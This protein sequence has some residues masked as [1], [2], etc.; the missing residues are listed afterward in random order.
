MTCEC[1][2]I[3]PDVSGHA[4]YAFHDAPCEHASC[5]NC[6][7]SGVYPDVLDGLPDSWEPEVRGWL[8]H[9]L[10][11]AEA[12]FCVWSGLDSTDRMAAMAKVAV[13][14]AGP[15]MVDLVVTLVRADR[16]PMGG[17]PVDV[18]QG[19]CDRLAALERRRGAA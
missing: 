14:R 16:L 1:D 9:G 3:D 12:A 4:G 5:E 18:V 8:A 19:I 7:W 6:G 10:T 15:M 17:N 13:E 2:I 11:P